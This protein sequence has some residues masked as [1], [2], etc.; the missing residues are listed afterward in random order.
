MGKRC[1]NSQFWIRD[2]VQGSLGFI[3][4][5]GSHPIIS[6][7][8]PLLPCSFFFLLLYLFYSCIPY[9]FF[10]SLKATLDFLTVHK[11]RLHA[12]NAGDMGLI[13]GWGTKIRHAT[14]ATKKNFFLVNFKKF[15]KAA[16]QFS[17]KALRLSC[18]SGFPWF[19]CDMQDKQGFSLLA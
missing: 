11:L 9:L 3:Q 12:P 16:F 15:K 14:G 4:S 13:P 8:Q 18:D 5:H 17:K 2:V 19:C 1:S 7:P 6:L 10:F